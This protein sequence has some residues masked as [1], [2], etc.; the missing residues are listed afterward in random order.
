MAMAPKKNT[1]IQGKVPLMASHSSSV[2]KEVMFSS[3]LEA[4]RLIFPSNVEFSMV[5]IFVSDYFDHFIGNFTDCQRT[6]SIF[7]QFEDIIL[8]SVHSSSNSNNKFP[9]RRFAQSSRHK[10]SI[11]MRNTRALEKPLRARN[12]YAVCNRAEPKRTGIVHNVAGW[13]KQFGPLAR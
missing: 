8:F 10:N 1:T 3:L 9:I 7:Q 5:S 12:A 11:I 6:F 13:Q 4:F 2:K